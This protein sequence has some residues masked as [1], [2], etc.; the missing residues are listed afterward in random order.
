MKL[1]S[2]GKLSVQGTH[3][4]IES[5]YETLLSLQNILETVT[6]M[7]ESYLNLNNRGSLVLGQEQDGLL[8]GGFFDQEQAFSGQMTQVEMWSGN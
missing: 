5:Y 4:S 3:R 8:T 6:M 7:K 2:D 1:Y